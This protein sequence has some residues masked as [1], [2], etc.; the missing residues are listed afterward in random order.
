MSDYFFY[1]NLWWEKGEFSEKAKWEEVTLPYVL[2]KGVAIDDYEER[3]E[4]FSIHRCWEWLNGEVLIYELSSMSH[5]VCIGAIVKQINKGC[6][7]ADETNAE[8][9]GTGSTRTRDRNHGKEPDASFRPKKMTVDA[10]NGSNGNNCPWPNLVV[11]VAYTETLDHAEEALKYWMSPGR[12]HDCIIVKV[13]PVS[14]DRVPVR[15]RAWHYC[16]LAGRK[17]RNTVPLVTTF[18]F[19]TQDDMGVPLT[20]TQGQCVINIS[21]SCLYHDFKQPDPPE[22]PIQPQT[23]LPDPIPLDFYFVQ[24]TIRRVLDY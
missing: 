5:E 12:A 3:V 23:L 21:L 10:P 6:G 22:P 7:N 4:K 24:Q 16:V 18:E 14:Q 1:R 8:I 11:E 20:I 15:M 19:G 9:Y 2:A 13:D 17:T